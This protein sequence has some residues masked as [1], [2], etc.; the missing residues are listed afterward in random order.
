MGGNHVFALCSLYAHRFQQRSTPFGCNLF[1]FRDYFLA[2][3]V[4]MVRSHVIASPE[5]ALT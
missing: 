1:P 3:S 4:D 2:F 5:L